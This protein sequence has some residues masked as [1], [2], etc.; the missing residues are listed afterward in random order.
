M[1]LTSQWIGGIL[2][3]VSVTFAIET[4]A[5]AAKNPAPDAQAV[6]SQTT[7]DKPITPAETLRM[8]VQTRLA[9]TATTEQNKR[10]KQ[11]LAAYY[12]VP[13]Q[14]LLWVDK[15]GLTRRGKA[16]IAEIKKA[17]DYG[18]QASDYALP[19]LSDFSRRASDAT[20]RLAEAEIQISRAALGYANDARGGRLNPRGISRSLDPILSLP[21]PLEVMESMAAHSDP[22]AYLRSFQPQYAQFERL[23]KKLIAL[24][25]GDETVNDET[26]EIQIPDG[27][28]LQLGVNN[29]QVAL[30]RTRLDVPPGKT[31]E[32]FDE[33]VEQAVTHFQATHNTPADGVVGPN[34]RRLLNA[35]HF[36]HENITINTVL[37]NM[38]RWRWL[39]QNLGSFYI[40][41]NIPE[42]TLRVM[43]DDEIFHS[44][45]VIVGKPY[46]PT[47]VF[48]DEIET[49]VFGPYWNVP[50]SIKAREIRPQIQRTGGV[51]RGRWNTEVLQKHGLRVRQDGHEVD[52]ATLNWDQVNIRA[53]ELFQPPGPNNVLGRV[54]F[55]FPNHYHV[56]MHDTP[57]KQLFSKAIRAK[58]HGCIRVQGADQLATIV[59]RHDSD[60]HPERTLSAFRTAYNQH[61]SLKRHIPVYITYFTLWVNEDQS[62]RYF[63]DLYGHDRRIGAALF[64]SQPHAT[65]EDT[66]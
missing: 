33:T 3:I 1:R 8:A 11:A 63:S 46:T 30:L 37:L 14:K 7:D 66:P 58:S 17:D 10:T 56:Y 57:H 38:E 29:P 45:R 34:T 40:M 60:W 61:S 47:P 13:D 25:R 64:D 50:P 54:K 24:R 31:P 49:V 65:T 52:P 43:N 32:Q 62:I 12:A 26:P 48:T 28:P 51:A 21:K 53:L 35:P 36:R 2:L 9:A 42:F 41:V 18:L 15:N 23:R 16:V 19:D 4:A 39:P 59:M 22:A 27:P 44:A 5:S 6:A 20:D 55:I